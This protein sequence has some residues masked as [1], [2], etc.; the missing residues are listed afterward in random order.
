MSDAEIDG[1]RERVWTRLEANDPLLVATVIGAIYLLYVVLTFVGPSEGDVGAIVSNLQTITFWT[2]LYAMMVLALNLHWGY[3]GLFNIGVAGFMAVGVY[4]F[5]ALTIPLSGAPPGLGLPIWVGI[6]GAML[7]TALVGALTALPA[8]R[9]R[10]DYLAIV[11]VALSEIIRLS[12]LSTEFEQFT[13]FTNLGFLPDIALGTGA[14]RGINIPVNPSIPVKSLYYTNPQ[15]PASGSRTALGQTVLT[16]FENAGVR[17][18]VVV[19]L[20]YTLVLVAVVALFYWLLVRVGNSPFGRVLK[21]IREDELVANSLGKDTRVFKI[22]VFMLGCALMGLGGVLWEAQKGFT[23]PTSTTFRPLQTFYI[24]I[25]LIIGGAGSNTGS[26]I[27]G[28]LF[29]SLLFQGPLFAARI[30]RHIF[31][32]GNAPSS[33]AVAAGQFLSGDLGALPAY[34]ASEISTLRFVLLGVVLVYLMQNRPQGLLGHRKEVAAS[35]D[36]MDRNGDRPAADGGRPTGND[37]PDGG[38]TDE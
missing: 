35:V 2:A 33:F 11:T 38:E 14:G 21:A 34:A 28:A 18:T 12:F 19:S 36:L 29:A 31:D 6:V 30:A 24:F 20:T 4:V 25:A 9:L 10:A 16:A 1:V 32:L 26:V 17:E 8:L 23:D 13:L 5:A 15:N 27:G 3:A 37:P 7:A 22:T